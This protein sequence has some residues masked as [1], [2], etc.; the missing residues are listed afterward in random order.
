MRLRRQTDPAVPPGV[1]RND[2]CP[3]GSGRK[4]KQCCLGKPV[5]WSAPSASA[6]PVAARLE[7]IARL[8]DDGRLLEAA[9]LAQEY[10]ARHPIDAKAH[11]ALG[12]VHLHAGRAGDAL[13]GFLQAVRLAPD[14]ATHHGNAGFALAQLGRDGEA[15]TAFQQAIALDPAL[16]EAHEQLGMLLQNHGLRREATEAFRRVAEI[17]PDTALGRINRAKVL[18]EED[19]PT[20]AEDHL[21]QTI[22]LYPTHSEAKRFLATYLREHGRFD[23]A[24]P[25]LE[26]ATEGNP[27]QAATAYFDMAMSKRITEADR[28]MLDQM[29][30]LLGYRPLQPVAR[31][32]VHFGLGKAMDDLRNYQEAMHHFDAANRIAGEARHFDRAHFGASVQRLINTTTAEFFTEH[33]N[34]GSHSELPV[35][36]LG[37]P[38][39]GTTLVEQIVSS[40]PAVDGGDELPFWNRAAEEFARFGEAA[41]TPDYFRR[42]AADYE[43]VLRRI[44]PT[45]LRVTDKMPGNFLWLG[46][47]HMIFPRG[48][49]I[50]CRR[51]PLD[52]CL[53]NYFAD[54]ASPLTFTYRRG[55]LAFYFRCYGRLMQHWRDI[56]PPG[57][58]LEVDYEDLVVE[59]ERLTR[60]MIAFIGLDWDDRCLRPQNNQRTVKTASMWQARQPTY[61][62]SIERW[63]NYEPWL[64]ELRDLLDDPDGSKQPQPVSDNAK[65]PL[66]QRLREAGRYDEALAAL[67]D[68][69]RADPNDAVMYCDAGTVCLLSGRVE[70]AVDCF[71]RAIGL[72]PNFAVAHYNLGAALERQGR[73]DD[74]IAALR[75]AIAFTSNLGRAYSRLGNLLQE[76][77][78]PSEAR[79][80]FQ[81]ASEWLED[82]A[83]RELEQAKLLL[84]DARPILAEPLLRNVIAAQPTN[85][86]AHVIL[87]DVLGEFGR[88][89]EATEAL[90]TALELDPERVAAWHSMANLTSFSD[91]DR[92][93]LGRMQ[94]L[95]AQPGRSEFERISLHFALGKA[96]DDLHEYREAIEHFDLANALEHRRHPFDR[97]A[98]AALVDRLI[99][100]PSGMS[101]ASDSAVPVFIIGMPCS[102]TTLVEQIVAAHP[103]VAT[104]GGLTFRA[105]DGD[106][107]G[108]DYLE[109]FAAIPCGA[110]RITD[111]NPCNFLHVGRISRALPNARFIHCR[112]DPRDTCL[113]IYCTRFARTQ[114]FAHD[115]GDLAFYYRQ[116]QRLMAHWRT[117]LPS[118]RLLEIDC[119][120]LSAD[121]E[122]HIRRMIAVL[123]PR[124]AR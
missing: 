79:T 55:D 37:M 65:L 116:Y 24:I 95:L 36:I 106:A 23:A 52:T 73:T 16:A 41:M 80:C 119:E 20:A 5:A 21:R 9:R 26:E 108:H 43:A 15:M 94:E 118:D 81:Q 51:H 56:L 50:H 39:S 19:D 104:G 31:Q 90:H 45:A 57:V 8:R 87:G 11:S 34:L 70:L 59:P 27:S 84:V 44:G 121:P 102:C 25:L 100:A 105:D 123:W 67:Q 10:V 14:V 3:C 74:A 78:N 97:A 6:P 48:R 4:Y 29:E 1:G 62:S 60:E 47:F 46:L 92:P 33:R 109:Q 63:R 12:L 83:E 114:S 71:E 107:S 42:V 75:R 91:A 99:N 64:G 93:M 49:V 54:F 82:P 35:L 68:G 103:A 28:P 53:S 96:H 17:E 117:L 120:R 61:R 38:R 110:A 40:H 7:Q 72:S 69:L 86:L 76:Q 115:R 111:T 2:P 112:R 13:R 89:R 101:P 113:S 22:A 122:P 18:F 85:S 30:A 58:M 88:L 98:F 124:L 66:A 77:G 32:R